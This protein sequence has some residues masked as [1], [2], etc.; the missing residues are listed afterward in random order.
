MK[1]LVAAI[2][3]I[4]LLSS[5]AA[6][7]GLAGVFLPFAPHTAVASFPDG[8]GEETYW[9]P[10]FGTPTPRPTFPLVTMYIVT[11]RPTDA[12]TTRPTTRPTNRPTTRPTNRPASDPTNE[13][14]AGGGQYLTSEGPLFLSFR[15]N[16]TEKYYMFTPMDLSVDGEYHFPLIGSSSQVVGDARVVVSSGMAIVRYYLVNGVH[17]NPEDEF[18]TFFPDIRSVWAVEPAQLQDIKLKFGTPYSVAM[19]LESDPSVLLYINCPVSY[20][21]GLGG[22]EDFSF[23]DPEYLE[24]VMEFVKLMD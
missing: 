7:A 16:L 2:S 3:V 9:G 18:F 4:A 6:L 13:P 24:K 15:R 8:G 14:S 5:V 22:L 21:T 19:W 1:K 17:L 20:N 23:E 10:E 11:P 12:P